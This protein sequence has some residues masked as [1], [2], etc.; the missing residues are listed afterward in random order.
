MK[1]CKTNLFFILDVSPFGKLIFEML[2]SL[3]EWKHLQIKD[4][5]PPK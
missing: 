1:K 4:R 2:E 5:T 3:A